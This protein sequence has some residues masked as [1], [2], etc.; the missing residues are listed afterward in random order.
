MKV[1]NGNKYMYKTKNVACIQV[2]ILYAHFAPLP[3][4]CGNLLL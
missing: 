3:R 1:K 2:Q 4:V